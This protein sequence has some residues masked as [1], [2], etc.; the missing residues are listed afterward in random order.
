MQHQTYRIQKTYVDTAPLAIT[1]TPAGWT[2]NTHVKLSN[3]AEAANFAPLFQWYRI[4]RVRVE[5]VSPFNIN[6]DG[7]GQGSALTMYTKKEEVL[8]ETV[9]TTENAWGEIRSKRKQDFG[10]GNKRKLVFYYKPN[11]WENPSGLS[12]RKQFDQWQTTYTNGRDVEY[13]GLCGLL[14]PTGFR[15]LDSSDSMKMYVTLYMEFKGNQ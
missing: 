7:V 2:F 12:Y 5:I 9:P 13:G 4:N 1:G 8:N 6:Q 3:L 11:T 15:N 10:M 14:I